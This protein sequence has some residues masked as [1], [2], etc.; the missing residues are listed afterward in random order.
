ML[1][2]KNQNEVASFLNNSDCYVQPSIVTSTG[3]MEGIPVSLMEAM[4]SGLP[5][6]ATN[7]SGIP[8]LVKPDETGYLVP[9]EEPL[10]LAEAIMKVYEDPKR[11][12]HY[13]KTGR[14]FVLKEVQSFDQCSSPFKPIKVPYQRCFMEIKMYLR[15][16][17]R[18]WWLIVL[19]VLASLAASLTL[20]YFK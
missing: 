2:P 5:V 19:C 15:I 10:A 4:A 11:A 12:A 20:S 9:P 18:G 13:A 16:I 8:E 14:D 1:G 17:Q 7:I 6:V 3:K